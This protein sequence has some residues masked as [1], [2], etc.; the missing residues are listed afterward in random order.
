M[1][2]RHAG[3]GLGAVAV[4]MS[5]AAPALDFTLGVG[6]TFSC[7]SRGPGARMAGLTFLEPAPVLSTDEYGGRHYHPDDGNNVGVGTGYADLTAPVGQYC[8]GVFYRTDYRGSA[9]RDTLDVLVANHRRQPFDVG[10]RYELQ[11]GSTYLDMAGLKL[12]RV[13]DFEPAAGWSLQFGATAS[14]MKALTYR[15]DDLRGSAVASS[16]RY[17]VGTATLVRTESDYDPSDFNPFVGTG[18]PEGYGYAVDG[19]A[20]LRSPRGDTVTATVLDAYSTIRWNDVPQSIENADNETFRYDA[21]FNRQ[22]FVAGRDRRVNLSRHLDPRY[23]VAVSAPLQHGFSLFA[24]DDYLHH[25]HFPAAGIGYQRSGNYAELGIDLQAGAVSILLGHGWLRLSISA[26]DI[27]ISEATV[28]GA[29]VS[30]AGA[31]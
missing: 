9:S 20:V 6:P 31:W 7:Q 15:E 10:R 25:T 11:F 8:A 18:D 19:G 21:N 4:M 17:G 3:I 23:R 14:V 2:L 13:W 28:L 26:D 16:G 1:R 5:A 12:S 30:V 24:S 29:G 27:E 22:A